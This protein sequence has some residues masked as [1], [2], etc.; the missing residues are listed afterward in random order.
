MKY[1]TGMCVANVLTGVGNYS[2]N[3]AGTALYNA[4]ECGDNINIYATSGRE[5]KE[6]GGQNTHAARTR[7]YWLLR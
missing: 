6:E 4:F 1:G 7:G 5:G 2:D 3:V